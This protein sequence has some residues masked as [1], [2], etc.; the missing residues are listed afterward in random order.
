MNRHV[1]LPVLN[2]TGFVLLEPDRTEIDP[3]EWRRLTY[4]DWPEQSG[5]RFAPLA[6]ATGAM[7][8]NGFFEAV[9]PRADRDG[10]WIESQR[11]IAP[12]LVRRIQATG[13]RPGRC[14]V[15]ELQPTSYETALHSLHLDPN[16]W[17]NPDGE[18]WVVRSFTQLT[19]DPDSYMIL[20]E[21]PWDPATETRI[22]LP[23]GAQFIV[24]SQRLWHAVWHPGDRPRYCVV[25]S[26]TSGPEL[27]SWID[28]HRRAPQ[29][30]AEPVGLRR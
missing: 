23:A 19:D 8:C 17:L 15:I 14:R 7:D 16:N 5:T 4:Q 9:P 27:G 29:R 1:H 30:A 13:A 21:D 6:S 24:D 18:G 25:S 3:S 22:P 11:R 26:L 2:E 10:I 20:R 12:T 28:Q